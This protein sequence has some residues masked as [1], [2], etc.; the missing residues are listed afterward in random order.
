[1]ISDVVAPVLHNNAEPVDAVAVIFT[2]CPGQKFVGP[3]IT[4]DSVGNGKE[5]TVTEAGKE[6]QEFVPVAVT[7]Y[8]PA[9]LTLMSFVIAP[10]LQATVAPVEGVALKVTVFPGQNP[11]VAPLEIDSVGNGKEDTVTEAG[12]ERQEFVPVAVTVYVPAVLTVMSFVI[13]P[14]LHATVAPVE[15]VAVKVTVFP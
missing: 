5:D 12:K 6:R 9:V 8:V 13:A 2:C 14:L 1:M 3:S 10:L 15:G 11:A 4:I 7:V